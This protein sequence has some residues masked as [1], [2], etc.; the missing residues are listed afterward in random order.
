MAQAQG[1]DQQK[2]LDAAKAIEDVRS[3]I[4]LTGRIVNGKI[5]IDQHVLDEIARNYPNANR[6]FVAVNAPFDPT[7][8]RAGSNGV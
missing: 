6:S 2:V 4:V 7:A 8:V 5:E 1:P 3:G